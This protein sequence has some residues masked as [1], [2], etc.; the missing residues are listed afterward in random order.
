MSQF[1]NS[2]PKT[3]LAIGAIIAGFIFI[4]LNDP[5]RT[6]CDSQM[7]LF[8]E[9]QKSFLYPQKSNGIER[10][11]QIEDLIELCQ[12]DNSPGG[13]FELFVRLKKLAVDLENIPRQ[14]SET[15]SSENAI[16][17]WLWKSLKLMAQ[18]A[19]GE[20][21]PASYFD[22]HGWFDA[23]DI[24]LYC[25]LRGSAERIFGPEKFS[26]WRE[27]VIKDLPGA[28]RL[29]REQLWSKTIFST[30]CDSFR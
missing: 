4:I 8:R 10:P 9:A 27:G 30:S 6:V 7:E 2:L 5:P 26:Y 29:T 11:A 15:A 17:K 1:L 21:A 19:W 25:D 28:D 16:D 23:S 22:K 12:H 20:R 24:S 18:M 14:C 13:C 3:V